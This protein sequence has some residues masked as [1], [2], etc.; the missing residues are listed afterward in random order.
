MCLIAYDQSAYT[1]R[2]LLESER[3][4]FNNLQTFYIYLRDESPR[5]R[6][7][8]HW[9]DVSL[10]KGNFG[11]KERGH[12]SGGLIDMNLVPQC[13]AVCLSMRFPLE[14]HAVMF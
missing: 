14:L 13:I 8:H 3:P 10:Y 1:S 12:L 5:R 2:I 7:G 4:V 11:F 9:P 6:G